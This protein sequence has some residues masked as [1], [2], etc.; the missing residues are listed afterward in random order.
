[1]STPLHRTVWTMLAKLSHTRLRQHTALN[2]R[3]IAPAVVAIIM[4]AVVLVVGAAAA[5]A[6]VFLREEA[7]PPDQTA[8]LLPL[9]TQVYSS[10]NL[11]PGFGQ[12]GKFQDILKRF[13]Q[14]PR[15]QAKIDDF[16]NRAKDETG[17]HPEGDILPWLGPEVA[18]GVVDVVGSGVAVASGGVPLVVVLVGTSDPDGS[19]K[20]LD[21]WIEYLEGKED[22]EFET[23]EYRG[24]TVHS[25]QQDDQHYAAAC[26]YLVFASDRDLLEDTVDR[27][28]DGDETG[29]LYSSPRFQ[30]ARDS[31]PEA[32]FTTLY[33]DTEDIWNDVRR[34]F[35]G[36]FLSGQLRKQL[37][38]AIPEWAAMGASF[39]DRGVIMTASAPSSETTRDAR[40]LTN[41]LASARL[42]PAG[43]LA[44]LSL[45]FDPDLGPLR[46]QLSELRIED[47]VPDAVLPFRFGFGG[48]EDST[49]E[50]L[51]DGLLADLKLGTGLDLE[52]DVL[53]WMTGEVGVALLP[54]DFKAVEADPEAEPVQV[55]IAI[56]FD[57]A[58]RSSV[59][60]AVAQ[61]LGHEGLLELE[62]KEVAYGGGEG[63]VFDLG[64]IAGAAAYRPGYLILEEQLLLV[65]TERVLE[66]VGSVEQDKARSL[67]D[68]PE[69]RRL[70]GETS[71][72]RNP[73]FYLNI[74]DIVEAALRTL[75]AEQSKTYRDVIEPF[76]EPLRALLALVDTQEGLSRSSIVVTVE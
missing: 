19:D 3:G 54:T 53:D 16:F 48:E 60:K 33:V 24:L 40:L 72:T 11:R 61:L 55:A 49:L 52:E 50:S 6:L 57:P 64:D 30:R 65:S 58:K 18:V 25:E 8:K 26:G 47:L 45:A 70:L 5:A 66:V 74:R 67:A 42:F 28:V 14:H 1:M 10:L 4:V 59:D 46:E 44:M 68:E 12:L 27:I 41:P 31:L 23:D 35:L 22:L 39:I 36:A 37:D 34:Q 2:E 20:V 38:D 43:T 51:L 56:R 69:Y 71:G 17:V 13:R 62:K 76:V 9:G 7:H 73:L 15:F 63:M 29:S 32:R 75:D 21:S